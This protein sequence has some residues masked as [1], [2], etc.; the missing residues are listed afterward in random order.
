MGG[1]QGS[2]EADNDSKKELPMTSNTQITTNGTNGEQDD[3]LKKTGAY[4]NEAF[5]GIIVDGK[6]RRSTITTENQSGR[7]KPEFPSS[8]FALS[9][10]QV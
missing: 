10:L 3:A 5:D 4:E 9:S 1:D 8:T 6:L 7:T 2:P